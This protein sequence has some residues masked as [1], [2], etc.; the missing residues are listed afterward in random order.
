MA[1]KDA[2]KDPASFFPLLRLRDGCSPAP[3][4]RAPMPTPAAIRSF[5]IYSSPCVTR[6]DGMTRLLTAVSVQLAEAEAVLDTR[7]LS[8]DSCKILPVA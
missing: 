3:L 4:I 1:K 5:G 8:P 2:G 6:Y 7:M